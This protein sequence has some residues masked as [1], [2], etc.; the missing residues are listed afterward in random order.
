MQ[1]PEPARGLC[2]ALLCLLLQYM[3]DPEPIVSHSC[4]VALDML[5]F[6]RSGAFQYAD[7]GN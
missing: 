6:E 2:P 3:Q 4:E 7:E 5:E 1:D